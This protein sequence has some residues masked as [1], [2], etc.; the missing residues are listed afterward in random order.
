ML[1]I[2]VLV[3]EIGLD[4]YSPIQKHPLLG[5]IIAMC[6]IEDGLFPDKQER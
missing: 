3:N 1:D 5:N 2:H 6:Q 4:S